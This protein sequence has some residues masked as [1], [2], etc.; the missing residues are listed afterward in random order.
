MEFLS[1]ACDGLFQRCEDE[2]GSWHLP[3]DVITFYDI[4]FEICDTTS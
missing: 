2:S 3:N 1:A 4:T